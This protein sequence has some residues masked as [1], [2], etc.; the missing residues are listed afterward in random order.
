MHAVYLADSAVVLACRHMHAVY[1]ADS[2][3]VLA[4]RHM[5]AVYLAAAAVGGCA[6]VDLC[7]D[8]TH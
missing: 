4:Y 2:A 6:H 3:V 8:C 7:K 5:H 1:L